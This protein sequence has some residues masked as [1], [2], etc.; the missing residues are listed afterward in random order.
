MEFNL[1]INEIAKALNTTAEMVVELYPQLRTQ[2]VWLELAR[3]LT[4]MS[5]VMIIVLLLCLV[6]VWFWMIE[7]ADVEDKY[8]GIKRFNVIHI[9]LV[10]FVLILAISLFIKPILSPDV[11]ILKEF[12]KNIY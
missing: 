11:L 10:A 4:L 9:A 12:I 7:V 2:Y 6:G 3:S 8:K 1:I 5:I